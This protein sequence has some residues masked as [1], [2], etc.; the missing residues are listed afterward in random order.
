MVRMHRK[1]AHFMRLWYKNAVLQGGT[2]RIIHPPRG[3][4]CRFHIN[5]QKNDGSRAGAFRTG[6]GSVFQ[7][8]PRFFAS[9]FIFLSLPPLQNPLLRI[10]YCR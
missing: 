1:T 7:S 5:P 8:G 6:N 10:Y 9:V 4:G 3:K 2:G